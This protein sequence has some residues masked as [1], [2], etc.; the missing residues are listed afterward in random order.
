MKKYIIFDLDGTLIDSNQI[1]D[2][3]IIKEIGKKFPH[4]KNKI[5]H[6]LG[7]KNAGNSLKNTLDIV[8]EGEK[9]DTEKLAHKIYKKIFAQHKKIHFLPGVLKK[10]K[11]L[12]KQYT[13]FLSTG[14]ATDFAEKM[15]ES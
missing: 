3:T 10:I 12:S 1:I 4:L 8:F 5:T 13:L 7:E 11:K 14:S 9:I 15:L 2:Q 6:I